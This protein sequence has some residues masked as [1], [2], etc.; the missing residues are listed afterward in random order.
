[1]VVRCQSGEGAISDELVYFHLEG[2]HP[3]EIGSLKLPINTNVVEFSPTEGL[4]AIG[5]Q[6]SLAIY[7]VA[8]TLGEFGQELF[9]LPGHAGAQ[10][11]QLRF[12]PDGHSLLSADSS[13]RLIGW[14]S[15][16]TP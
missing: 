10:V 15:K 13:N 14:I 9:S 5:G 16:D 7:F 11:G 4:L 12:T 3:G 8:P 2:D 6:G 1:L